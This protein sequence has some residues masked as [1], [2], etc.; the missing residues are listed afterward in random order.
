MTV[1]T[2]DNAW[3]QS[4]LPPRS[5]TRTVVLPATGALILLRVAATTSRDDPTARLRS[6]AVPMKPLAP[7]TSIFMACHW[8]SRGAR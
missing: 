4:V 2:P 6:N 8:V 1:R 5:A 3:P 7:V